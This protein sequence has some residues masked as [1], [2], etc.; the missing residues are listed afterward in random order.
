MPLPLEECRHD[1]LPPPTSAARALAWSCL[2][3]LPFLVLYLFHYT[4][5]AGEPTGFIQGDMPYYCANGRAIFERGNGFAHPNPYDPDP[6]SPVIYFHWFTWVLGFGIKQLGLD[7]GLV[8]LAAGTLAGLACA[9]LTYLLVQSVLPDERY[10]GPLYLF[11]MWGGG[12]LCLAQ[13]LRNVLHGQ[14]A[15]YNLF[16]LDPFNGW[17]FLNWGRNLVYP[18]EAVYHALVAASWFGVVRRRWKLALGSA[19]L[20]AA[21][22]PFSGMQLLLMLAAWFTLRLVM[23]RDRTALWLWLGVLIL[24]TLFVGYYFGFL[25]RFPQ[26]RALRAEWSLDWTL[27]PSS[28][29]FAY[30]PIGLLAAYRLF[31]AEEKPD[32]QSMFFVVCFAVSF[33]LV[34]HEWFV[35]PRQPLHFTRGYVW[36]PLCL[37][38]LPALQ[39]FLIALGSRLPRANFTL[40]FLLLGAVSVSDNAL[41]LFRQAQGQWHGDAEGSYFLTP[42]E[43]AA[44]DWIGSHG[45]DGI[46]VCP[47]G[48]L[49]YLAAVYSSVRPYYGHW[50]NTPDY[51][52]RVKQVLDWFD[53]GTTGPWLEQVDYLLLPR[54]RPPASVSSYEWQE[55]YSNEEWRL[56]GRARGIMALD[57]DP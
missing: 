42:S 9:W 50:S 25:E 53:T 4:S 5:P 21:T 27:A 36:M 19:A 7:P 54:Q 29:L 37:I 6:G 26:H 16:A 24:L 2:A 22:H 32:R 35:S 23:D 47:D 20:L 18:T 34:K 11:T 45:L 44:L 13:I 33:F 39:K 10:L 1:V 43:R 28:M 14:Q 56:L 48:K 52:Q 30:G 15:G 38:A 51:K 17:W 12:L 8:F 40:A 3:A 55:I 31:F 49:S 57:A 46:L 41:F